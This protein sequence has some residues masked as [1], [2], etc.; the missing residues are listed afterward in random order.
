[1]AQPMEVTLSDEKKNNSLIALNF[2][3][4]GEMKECMGRKRIVFRGG[5]LQMKGDD[6]I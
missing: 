1:M 5:H 2:V 4:E 6:S 3:C